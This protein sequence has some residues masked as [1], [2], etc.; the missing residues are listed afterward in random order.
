MTRQQKEMIVLNV[1]GAHRILEV[2]ISG[3]L[4]SEKRCICGKSPVQLGHIAHQIVLSLEQ[5]ERL[6]KHE[7]QETRT[8]NRRNFNIFAAAR[9]LVRT[10]REI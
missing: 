8:T 10:F 5:F 9:R 7:H 4:K 6:E 2:P 1:L 3:G